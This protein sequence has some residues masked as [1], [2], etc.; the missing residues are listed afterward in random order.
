MVNGDG[1]QEDLISALLCS[2]IVASSRDES[3][4]QKQE[5]LTTRSLSISAKPI[6]NRRKS[7]SPIAATDPAHRECLF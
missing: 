7:Q 1:W 2:R 4:V 3:I 6:A 5:V